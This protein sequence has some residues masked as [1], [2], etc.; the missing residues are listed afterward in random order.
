MTMYSAHL[1]DWVC[2]NVNLIFMTI[3]ALLVWV[4][5]GDWPKPRHSWFVLLSSIFLIGGAGADHAQLDKSMKQS[6]LWQLSNQCGNRTKLNIYMTEQN[7]HRAQDLTT[8]HS[9]P[10]LH[11]NADQQ[12]T[13][14]LPMAWSAQVQNEKVGSDHRTA[15]HLPLVSILQLQLIKN[16]SCKSP[17]E[18]KAKASKQITSDAI[19]TP[20]WDRLLPPSNTYFSV[21]KIIHGY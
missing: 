20:S 2:D 21:S 10:C 7:G 13:T 12:A 17:Q 8:M 5:T 4:F 15:F 9:R 6:T 11:P 18:P 1:I 16:F 19:S 14:H 3:F